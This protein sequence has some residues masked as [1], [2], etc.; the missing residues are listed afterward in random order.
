MPPL[1]RG[2]SGDL[3]A[4][5]SSRDTR[6]PP[7]LRWLLPPETRVEPQVR[8]TTPLLPCVAAGVPLAPGPT[9]CRRV[10]EPPSIGGGAP[11]PTPPQ[12]LDEPRIL[13]AP[14]IRGLEAAVC[15]GECEDTFPSL[16][17][18]RLTRPR[19]L[20]SVPPLPSGLCRL[21]EREV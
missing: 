8:P 9:P 1:P 16:A 12:R 7:P 21:R 14:V 18:P 20:R 17:G 11:P 15:H 19:L 3:V 2:T 4:A 13:E 10:V 5:S 6:A